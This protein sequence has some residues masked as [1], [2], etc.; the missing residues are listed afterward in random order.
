MGEADLKIV[1]NLFISNQAVLAEK[2]T[3]K[4]IIVI[5]YF[6]VGVAIHR[7]VSSAILSSN[8]LSQCAFL[9]GRVFI[10]F[11]KRTRSKMTAF[12]ESM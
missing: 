6:E 11:Q 4:S 2:V 5:C 12:I 1:S 3:S 9:N 8:L 7:C 10:L